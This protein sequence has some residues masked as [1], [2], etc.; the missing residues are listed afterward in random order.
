[1]K[2]SIKPTAHRLLYLGVITALLP[3][4]QTQAQDSDTEIEEVVVTGSFIRNSSFNGASPIDTLTAESVLDSGTIT[5][6]E[7]MRDLT[8]TANTDVVSNVLGG[9]GGGQQGTEA[10]F[11]LRG[12]GGSSTLTLLFLKWYGS[13]RSD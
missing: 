2:L 4:S 8:Y 6:G 5:V 12:L 9:P 13:F 1:M 7:Y 3:L 10:G 11:N